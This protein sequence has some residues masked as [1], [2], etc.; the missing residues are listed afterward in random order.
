MTTRSTLSIRS[1]L[2]NRSNLSL[3]TIGGTSLI[4]QGS[5]DE[6]MI[7]NTFAN[8]CDNMYTEI[9]IQILNSNN[10][11]SED[12]QSQPIPIENL[13]D[14]MRNA[15]NFSVEKHSQLLNIAMCR[16]GPT[17]LLNIGIIK[18]KDLLPKDFKGVLGYFINLY[19]QSNVAIQYHTSAKYITSNPTW[20]EFFFFPLRGDPKKE[21]LIAEVCKL[22][23]PDQENNQKSN[24]LGDFK[25]YFKLI[26]KPSV[27]KAF[28]VI[29]RTEVPLNSIGGSG[30]RV[31]YTFKKGLRNPQK[32][33]S[34]LMQL[35]ISVEKETR[36]V[37]QEHEVLL[38]R[39]LRYEQQK[40][41]NS[42]LW[43]GKLS[44]EADAIIRQHYLQ[45]G[46][47]EH[48]HLFMKWIAYS[49]I[50]EE[51]HI[52]FGLLRATL[53]EVIKIIPY[54][55][56]PECVQEF[57]NSIQGIL[58]SCFDVIWK[59]RNDIFTQ[60]Q[61]ILML[62]D[63]LGIFQEIDLLNIPE[64]V[65]LL[66]NLDLGWLDKSDDE[67]SIESLSQVLNESI[68]RCTT[69]WLRSVVEFFKIEN[70][71][72]VQRTIQIIQK[73][74]FDIKRAIDFH[75]THFM[76]IMNIKYA[77]IL[78]ECYVKT[79]IRICKPTILEACRNLPPLHVIDVSNFAEFSK[80]SDSTGTG[81]KQLFEIY[82][83][84]KRLVSLGSNLN[85]LDDDE[86]VNLE[87]HEW[88]SPVVP[89]WV[90]TAI[91]NALIAI[92]KSIDLDEF[93]TIDEHVR[94]SSSAL[95]TLS[96]FYQI[97]VFWDQIDWPNTE[98]MFLFF[99]RI[100][101]GICRC[102]IYYATNISSKVSKFNRKDENLS[103]FKIANEW[104]IATCNINEI[105]NK[106]STFVNNDM[107]AESIIEQIKVNLNP[108][109]AE[110]CSKTVKNIVSNCQDNLE[111]EIK[112][113][114]EAKNSEIVSMIQDFILINIENLNKDVNSFEPIFLFLDRNLFILNT[115]LFEST[116]EAMVENLHQRLLTVL[117]KIAQSC[118]ESYRPP[119]FF[120][121]LREVINIMTV[122]MNND[123]N[124]LSKKISTQL[125]TIHE[126][127][128][129]HAAKTETLI[130]KYYEEILQ[131]Q[132]NIPTSSYGQLTIKANISS[133]NI[134][135]VIILNGKN[136][137]PDSSKKYTNSYVK[138]H[139]VPAD[140][141][142]RVPTQ[143]TAVKSKTIYPLFDEEFKI[144][145]STSQQ[146]LNDNILIFIVK[147]KDLFRMSNKYL[148]ECY[149]SFEDIRKSNGEQIHLNLFR[150]ECGDL[151]SDIICELEYRKFY[152]RTAQY[153][154]N[155]L[156][157]K[158]F[159]K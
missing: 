146:L 132:K 111:N 16:K 91:K 15:F 31:W 79:L 13:M 119:S 77:N 48:E 104:C 38:M 61:G 95:D 137:L 101:D 156:T 36:I 158:N 115:E 70:K 2:S 33:G 87:Y 6:I 52:S 27:S 124:L 24:M 94:H 44:V 54:I 88:F 78:Y 58:P 18:V 128:E 60:K 122:C 45:S 11:T 39:L 141:F 113:L 116:F 51:N 96:I 75:H 76:E 147:S 135:N 126:F 34:V 151:N 112:I 125:K 35:G 97:K 85:K 106:L 17:F 143:K 140:R 71:D 142:S 84:V 107:G 74:C 105:T 1:N 56:G 138:M 92:K 130:H 114:I 81:H 83:A 23:N 63:V 102:C 93:K 148:S 41:P 72:P 67:N 14:L 3:H 99:G 19:M 32:R 149:L 68:R 134:L 109:E 47:S 159:C 89:F 7:K 152:D 82:L 43:D 21:T 46:L 118:T 49:S 12:F 55:S 25:N 62:I 103:D 5:G 73:L 86:M 20:D 131:K 80:D 157:E 150:P 100:V 26:R 120:C 28:K 145:L 64:D 153:F 121:N 59:I 65:E 108:P 136:I 10:T 57:W 9:L 139:C 117:Y 123:Q 144:S 22:L 42:A 8:N 40:S 53:Q 155:K 29:G 69:E 129:L 127:L 37:A 90:E 30:V 110:R 133:S 4:S 66:A 50:H 154:I 98:T